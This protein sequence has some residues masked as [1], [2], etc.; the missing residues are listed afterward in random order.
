[1]TRLGVLRNVVDCIGDEAE[2]GFWR[3]L[4]LRLVWLYLLLYLRLCFLLL[5]YDFRAP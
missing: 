2:S 1:M 5:V 4:I 3:R